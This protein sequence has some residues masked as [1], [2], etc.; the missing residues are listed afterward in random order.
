MSTISCRDRA[1]MVG[2]KRRKEICAVSL[3]SAVTRE[4]VGEGAR[5]A[6]TSSVRFRGKSED[7]GGRHKRCRPLAER[8]IM[9]GGRRYGMD[10]L[11]TMT[12]CDFHT[13]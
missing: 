4:E 6:G 11:E 8:A 5:K 2:W 3:E 10:D 7:D 1:A 13:Y 9:N 12:D